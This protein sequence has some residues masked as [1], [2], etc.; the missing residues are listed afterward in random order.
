MDITLDPALLQAALDSG[1][2]E[3]TIINR[4]EKLSAEPLPYKDLGES[5]I[6]SI[7]KDE[8]ITLPLIEV[9]LRAFTSTSAR[10]SS[11]SLYD[12]AAPP[13]LME[14]GLH[15]LSSKDSNLLPDIRKA[16]DTWVRACMIQDKQYKSDRPQMVR[17][18][19]GSRSREAMATAC[20][21]KEETAA[22]WLRGDKPGS[23]SQ[24]RLYAL[25]GHLVEGKY[26][27]LSHLADD[28]FINWWFTPHPDLGGLSPLEAHNSRGMARIN[29]DIVMQEEY[30]A[31][32]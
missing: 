25:T 28:D 20:G 19:L 29:I 18:I 5:L 23:S 8:D 14:S 21:V 12:K 9:M 7:D 31:Q 27:Y 4:T 16:T 1:I 17:E 15:W 32:R 6:R 3:E 11:V 13:S 10:M 30:N 22:R 24:L 2:C 26:L